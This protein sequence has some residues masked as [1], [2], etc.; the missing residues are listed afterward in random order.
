M[1]RE[2]VDQTAEP[3][4]G[5]GGPAVLEKGP[6]QPQEGLRCS[7][8]WPLLWR[9]SHST[10]LLLTLDAT[11]YKMFDRSLCNCRVG[12]FIFQMSE[13]SL[14]FVYMDSYTYSRIY[15]MIHCCRRQLYFEKKSASIL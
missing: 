2:E 11:I 4:R 7:V 6:A 9:Q 15:N 14:Q 3:L 5:V 8:A 10:S 12:T 13:M 1:L